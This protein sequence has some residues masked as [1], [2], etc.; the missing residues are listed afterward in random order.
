MDVAGADVD[1][2]YGQPQ[3]APPLALQSSFAAFL[4]GEEIGTYEMR[5]ALKGPYVEGEVW[6]WRRECRQRSFRARRFGPYR[7]M[8]SSCGEQ[9]S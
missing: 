4:G 2:L 7:S 8:A 1:A 5:V 6:A 3:R 9:C